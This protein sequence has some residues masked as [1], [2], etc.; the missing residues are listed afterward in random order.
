MSGPSVVSIPQAQ[1][2]SDDSTAQDGD[3]QGV[4]ELQTRPVAT[5]VMAYVEAN[6]SAPSIVE[7]HEVGLSA[8]VD[9]LVRIVTVEGPI[10]EEEI[11]RRY[12]SVCGKDRTGNRIQE[13]TREALAQ[14]VRQ[15]KMSVE[16]PFYALAP[17][18]ECSPRDRSATRSTTLRRPEMLPPVEIRTALRQVVLEHIGVE[19]R[20]AIV[21]VSHMLGFQRTGAELQRVLEEQLRLMLGEA[22]LVLRNGNKLYT[23]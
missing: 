7:P 4:F 1:I 17:M 19:P 14:A 11:A 6:V 16:G 5:A 13:A 12:A 18:S 2:I 10:H 23:S 3:G 21:E 20:S 22:L 15:G 8:R 9:I